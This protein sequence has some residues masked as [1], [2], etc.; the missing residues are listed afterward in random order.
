MEGASVGVVGVWRH[1]RGQAFVHMLQVGPF[2]CVVIG[3]HG[4][5]GP[6]VN[7]R[8][9]QGA[10]VVHDWRGDP[11]WLVV[12]V[13]PSSIGVVTSV[14]YSVAKGGRVTEN[15]SSSEEQADRRGAAVNTRPVQ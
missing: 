4:G 5:R 10:G 3:G 2:E 12:V 9:G 13:I 6:V 15:R 1:R 8:R 7:H 14:N 11:W